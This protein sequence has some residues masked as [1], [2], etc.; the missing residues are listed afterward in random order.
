MSATPERDYNSLSW[1]HR[2]SNFYKKFDKVC[3]ICGRNRNQTS[4][5]LHHLSYDAEWCKEPDS[6]L[7][8]LCGDH[9]LQVHEFYNLV[10]SAID[11]REATIRFIQEGLATIEPLELE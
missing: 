7:I 4:I 10:S 3:V 11:L 6:D 1:R 9:H 2:R 5:H 8:P